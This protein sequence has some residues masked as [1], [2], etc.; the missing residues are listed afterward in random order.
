MPLSAFFFSVLLYNHLKY[1]VFLT[2]QAVMVRKSPLRVV[3][4]YDCARDAGK[5]MPIKVPTHTHHD[6]DY[7]GIGCLAISGATG[8]WT[9]PLRDPRFGSKGTEPEHVAAVGF[10][11]VMKQF[12]TDERRALCFVPYNWTKTFRGEGDGGGSRSAPVR[13]WD[14][15][16]HA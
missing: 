7:Q 13:H 11:I 4:L 9:T 14:R 16:P 3:S 6:T 5:A 15:I 8:P 2:K 12:F 1:V 10:P